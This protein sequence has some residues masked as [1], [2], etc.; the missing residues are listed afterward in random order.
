[1]KVELFEIEEINASEASAMAADSSAITL[2]DK[3]G[4]SGQKTLV[5]SETATRQTYR[6]MTLIEDLVFRTLFPE[7]TR[8]E[9]FATEIIPLR[10]LEALQKAKD[11]G[12][13]L[14]FEVWHSRTRKDDP[15]LVAFTGEKAPQTWDANY[16][17]ESGRFLIARWGE[18]LASFSELAREAKSAWKAVRKAAAKRQLIKAETALKMLDEDADAAFQGGNEPEAI[19]E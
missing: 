2:I 6:R 4:L 12:Q 11:S 3:L 18:A 9:N 15:L 7:R 16:F 14:S 1:M 8:V 10:V 19:R 5:S 17:H 13:F